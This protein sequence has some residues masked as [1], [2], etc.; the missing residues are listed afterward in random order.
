MVPQLP[1]ETFWT[2]SRYLAE[3]ICPSAT[4]ILN[5]QIKLFLQR[6]E[7]GGY[8]ASLNEGQSGHKGKEIIEMF[9]YSYRE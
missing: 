6:K 7:G 1:M 4:L 2:V 9:S 8:S 3:N 5:A